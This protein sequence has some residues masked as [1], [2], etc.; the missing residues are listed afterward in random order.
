MT[1]QEDDRSALAVGY[2]WATQ[3]IGIGIEFVL[4][5]LVGVWLDRKAG[6]LILFTI[7]GVILGL[8]IGFLALRDLLKL[9][10]KSRK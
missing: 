10:S 4:P 6:T 8:V 2:G 1:K 3:I 7:F 5:I 9:S